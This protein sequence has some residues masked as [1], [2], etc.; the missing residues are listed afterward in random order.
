MSALPYFHQL[1]PIALQLGPVALH[2]YGISYLCAFGAFYWLARVRSRTYPEWDKEAI[3]DILFYG[4]LGVILGGRIGYALIYGWAEFSANPLSIFKIWTGGMSFHG[5]LIG[6]IIAMVVF[7]RRKGRHPFDLLDFV[8]PC[9]PIGLGFGR[10]GNFINGELWGRLTD[11]PWGMIFPQ[12]LGALGLSPEALKADYLSGALNSY[13]RHPSPLYQ[14]FAEGVV[15]FVLLW[16]L[17]RRRT[18]RFFAS[19]LF[20]LL[21]GVLRFI[22]EYFREPDPQM[23]YLAFGWLT[24]GQLLSVPLVVLGVFLLILSTRQKNAAVP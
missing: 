15:M 24:T 5:G 13:A 10:I 9:I 7:A 20:V 1:D 14:A 3:S 22:T 18:A 6:V 21:Y 12:S 16:L 11:S 23:G 4:A 2:W 17:T 19:G 8:A